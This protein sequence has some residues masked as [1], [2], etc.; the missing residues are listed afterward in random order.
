MKKI[1][2][3]VGNYKKNSS[4]VST[5]IDNYIIDLSG[6][7]NI[8]V[9]T[10]RTENSDELIEVFDKVTIYRVNDYV[11]LFENKLINSRSC[12]GFFKKMFRIIY[13]FLFKYFRP[14]EGD[15]GWS[16]RRTYKVY[17][18][19]T[20]D[21]KYD[22][23]ISVSDPFQSHIIA[24]YI[25]KKE[26][27]KWVS[28]FYDS[29]GLNKSRRGQFVRKI[30]RIKNEKSVI[31]HSTQTLLTP[32]LFNEY[33]ELK[34]LD[35]FENVIEQEYYTRRFDKENLNTNDYKGLIYV[36]EGYTNLIY[37]GN[38][39]DKIRNPQYMFR[40]L[41]NIELETRFNIIIMS[42]YSRE[43]ISSLNIDTNNLSIHEIQNHD[44]FI[45]NMHMADFLI[46][47]GN[48]V[49]SQV[50]AKIFQ[51]M[52]TGKPIIH[53]SKI[54]NDPV[55][56]YLKDYKNSLIVFETNNTQQNIK[57]VSQFIK[58]HQGSI[59]LEISENKSALNQFKEILDRG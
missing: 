4:S 10:N 26:G 36:K 6:E 12:S 50:P 57:L 2:F 15:N 30:L 16:K 17:K 58:M 28:Y 14:D 44:V 39:Y 40:I 53:F 1:L 25:N 31:K 35:N 18:K 41:T 46:S 45:N 37:G 23:I 7:Y 43:K 34:Y 49:H 32:E 29:F 19:I 8:D 9:I 42:N 21:S 33:N 13:Y 5:A 11:R 38:F 48:T 47:V 20:K 27:I 52:E 54:A 51:Y 55:E 24:K 59:I 22:L 3:I 56:R